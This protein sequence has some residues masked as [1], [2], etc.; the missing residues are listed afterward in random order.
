MIRRIS[1]WIDDVIWEI[2]LFVYRTEREDGIVANLIIP[3]IVSFI[4][5]ILTVALFKSP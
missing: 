2:K 5:A 3:T 4:T 1:R